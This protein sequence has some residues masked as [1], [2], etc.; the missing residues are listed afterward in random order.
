MTSTDQCRSCRIPGLV[1]TFLILSWICVVLRLYVRFRVVRTPGWDDLFV[2]FYLLSNTAGNISVCLAVEYGL[3]QHILL[4][5]PWKIQRYLQAFYV[6][7]ATY[8]ISTACIKLALLLQYLRVFERG[9]LMHRITFWLTVFT[10]LWG[11]AYST[12]A[13]FPCVPVTD[14]W[15]LVTDGSRCYGYGSHDPASFVATYESHT[16][17]NMT[18][19]VLLLIIPLPLLWK[20]GTNSATRIRLV[21]LWS[22]GCLVIALAAWRLQQMIENQ[23]ATYPTRDPTWYGPTSILLAALELSAASICASVPIFWPVLTIEW[24]GIFVT[25]EVEITHESRY[26]EEDGE[27]L[28]GGST[29]SRSYSETEITIVD[30]SSGRNK[31]YRD[32]FILRQ[33]DPLRT[34]DEN[35]QPRASADAREDSRKWFRI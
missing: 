4:L 7:N 32:S 24:S 15:D 18:L 11:L 28:T 35:T 9:T 30:G 12:I 5:P 21:A 10:A 23:V 2:G 31:H 16:A 25:Q 33:V 17:I 34:R 3:G 26:N 27:S 13:W 6:S 19:D 14:F 22:F 29:H 1:I 8:C 20:H